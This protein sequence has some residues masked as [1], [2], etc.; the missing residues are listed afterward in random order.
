MTPDGPRTERVAEQV[1][2]LRPD[3]VEP[4][5][6]V[7]RGSLPYLRLVRAPAVFSALGDPLAG[8]LIAQGRV[9]PRAGTRLAGA[10]AA[11]YLA[12]M[13]LNDVADREEDARERPERPIPSGAVP[14]TTA[15][16]LGGGLLL[17]GIAAARN[18]G[19][20]AAGAKLAAAV[21]AYNVLLKR[22][23]VLGPVGMGLCRAL[24]LRMGARAGGRGGD[25]GRS[26][27]AES[28]VLGAYVAGLTWLARG[29]TGTRAAAATRGGA[30]L[31]GLALAAAAW[32]GGGAALPWVLAA[33][34]LAGPAVSRAV[35][36]PVPAR[37]G[38]AVGAMVR[39]VP[40]LDAAL[41]AP[42]APRA[43]VLLFPPLLALARW[44]RKLIPVH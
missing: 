36:E 21:A 40:A 8:M 35:R 37:V 6:S 12:G 15:A 42:R 5:S 39:A 41:A 27:D 7:L 24:S 3:G 20:G 28:A 44:G 26:A 10:A 11:L 43:A 1:A 16:L 4:G 38:P 19:A 9:E 22:S 32:R 14:V 23:A 18:A 29:E 34:A 13:A 2:G 31:S 17:A 30:A 33:A 25:G